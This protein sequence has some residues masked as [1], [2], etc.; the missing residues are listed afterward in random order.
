MDG[1]T[2]AVAVRR[3]VVQEMLLLVARMQ[4]VML[5]LLENM[6]LDMRVLI[7]LLMRVM[8]TEMQVRRLP[9]GRRQQPVTNRGCE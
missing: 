4:M 9:A 7:R 5:L 3:G 1:H 8:M 2:V 6:L